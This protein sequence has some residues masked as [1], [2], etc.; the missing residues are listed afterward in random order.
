MRQPEDS[1]SCSRSPGDGDL[2]PANGF[3]PAR[4]LGTGNAQTIWPHFFRRVPPLV[5]A[6]HEVWPDARGQDRSQDGLEDGLDVV[7][8]PTR[9]GR[10]GVVLWHG[11]EARADSTYMRGLAH[12]V[13]A[14]GW[15]VLAVSFPS[16]GPSGE[17][18][19]SLYH[20][21]KT[22]DVKGVLARARARWGTDEI[23]GV[24]VSLGGNMLLKYLGETGGASELAAAV[25]ISVPFDLGICAARLDGPGFFPWLYRER[26]LRSLRRKA[27][28]LARRDTTGA[29]DVAPSAGLRGL[30]DL[31]IAGIRT[32]ADFDDQV[33]APLFGFDDASDYWRRNS[34]RAFL[35]SIARP[36]LLISAKDDPFVGTDCLP[37]DAVAENPHVR[38]WLS[39]RG[40]HVGFVAGSLLRPRFVVDDL[41][42]QFLRAHLHP[43][44]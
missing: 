8:T 27:R 42:I 12:A 21:G 29:P 39:E 33:T 15:N 17:R 22:E 2:P 11:L 26:F 38:L 3:R 1:S 9:P 16:C 20:A 4:F 28:R 19:R 10:P 37:T 44:S 32:I 36:T 6:T 18:Q 34:S 5:G 30:T 13:R 24:G 35:P 31:S 23:A 25:A 43:R 14:A 7:A 41:T 40:G